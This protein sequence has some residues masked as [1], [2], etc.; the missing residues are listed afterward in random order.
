MPER[1]VTNS[2]GDK[3]GY[4]MKRCPGKTLHELEGTSVPLENIIGQIAVYMQHIMS[5]EIVPVIEHAANIMVDLATTPCSVYLIDTD[6]YTP[7]PQE[8][9][10]A[11]CD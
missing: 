10:V 5:L 8:L 4:I 6:G 9:S 2:V 3:V 1:T 7:L 11:A